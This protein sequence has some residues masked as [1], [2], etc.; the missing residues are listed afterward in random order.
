MVSFSAEVSEIPRNS[1]SPETEEEEEEDTEDTQTDS[2]STQ[3]EGGVV[4]D[5][6]KEFAQAL[7][8]MAEIV[9]TPLLDESSPP[10]A[11]SSRT[12]R[13][14]SSSLSPSPAPEGAEKPKGPPTK[15]KHVPASPCKQKCICIYCW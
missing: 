1:L 4:D 14:T 5:T 15:P 2:T 6:E 13:E 11:S 9:A 8:E 10:S 3:A 7:E 12:D